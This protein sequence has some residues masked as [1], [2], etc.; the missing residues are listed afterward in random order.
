MSIKVIET[1]LGQMTA[2]ASDR[3][4]HR[5]EFTS[6]LDVTA[7]PSK[8]IDQLEEELALYFEKKLQVFTV[9]LEPQG[10]SFQKAVWEELTKVPYGKTA[11]YRDIAEALN[12]PTAYRAAAQANGRNPIVIIIP[13]HR[14]INSNGALGGY[15]SGLERKKWLLAHENC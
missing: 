1:P 5:L 10:T 3:A 15:S 14:I 11:S 9:P 8:I 13:C 12:K 6:C 2:V 4:L 7:K